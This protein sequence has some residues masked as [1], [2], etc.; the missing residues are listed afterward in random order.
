[1][2]LNDEWVVEESLPVLDR[3]TLNDEANC[4]QQAA[5]MRL[6]YAIRENEMLNSGIEA[7]EVFSLAVNEYVEMGGDVR[8]GSLVDAMVG[9]ANFSR[10][11]CQ[12]SVIDAVRPSMWAIA[13]FLCNDVHPNNI[14]RWDGGKGER[15]GQ[16]AWDPGYPSVRLTAEID[17]LYSGAAA[18]VLHSIDWK[19]GRA[20]WTATDVSKA[21]QFQMHAMLVFMNYPE[22]DCL[23]V[24]VWNTRSNQ[25]TYPVQF[26]RK[27]IDAYKGRVIRAAVLWS[28][29]RELPIEKVEAW[30]SIEKCA[31]CPV[32]NHCN[33]IHQKHRDPVN[34]LRDLIVLEGASDAIKKQ[35]GGI[36][37]STG[38]D[39][40]APNGDAYG[41]GKVSTRAKPNALYKVGGGDD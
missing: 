6:G 36:V 8:P 30:P 9:A 5:L 2:S 22:V 11:D 32:A 17:L 14:L 15:S 13:N 26:E 27:N 24:S 3:S 31:E 1:M 16:L 19:S 18:K 37:K 35:L 33:R 7:H 20:H 28:K 29:N 10:P 41:Q 38:K 12:P 23:E 34:L 25:K 4:P 40:I 21:F 39:I